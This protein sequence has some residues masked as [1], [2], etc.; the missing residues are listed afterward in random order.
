MDFS[1]IFTTANVV[2]PLEGVIADFA[3]LVLTIIVS[4]VGFGLG[5]KWLRRAGK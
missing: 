4:L 5:I 1:T 3:P 2:T